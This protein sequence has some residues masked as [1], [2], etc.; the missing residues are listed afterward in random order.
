MGRFKTEGM[1]L[2]QLAALAIG[3]AYAIGG[4]IGFAVTGFGGFASS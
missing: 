3:L 2:A 1:S 4:V